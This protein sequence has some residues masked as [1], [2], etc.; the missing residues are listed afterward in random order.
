MKSS[1]LS[2]ILLLS[3]AALLPGCITIAPN[4]TARPLTIAPVGK[5]TFLPIQPNFKTVYYRVDRDHNVDVVLENAN[6]G[7]PSPDGVVQEIVLHI[8]WQPIGGRTSL[9]SDS[10]NATYRYVVLTP[11]GAGLYEGAGFVRFFDTVG[12]NKLRARVMDGDLRL[13]EASP[14]FVDTLGRSRLAGAFTARLNDS[15]TLARKIDMQRDFF[16]RTFKY[17]QATA[18]DKPATE[19]AE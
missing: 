3:I 16:I 18:P 10:L 12:K 1:T 4:L 11:K 9:N 2:L 6:R 5:K 14:G 13:S 19:P 15:E 8:F 7:K 17:A